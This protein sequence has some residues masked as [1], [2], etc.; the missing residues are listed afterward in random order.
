MNF[1]FN[2]SVPEHKN[3]TH[4]CKVKQEVEHYF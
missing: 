3:Q 1:L 2:L 4:E